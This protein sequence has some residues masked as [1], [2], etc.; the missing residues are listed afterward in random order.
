M[1]N[2]YPSLN[3]AELKSELMEAFGTKGSLGLDQQLELMLSLNKGESELFVTF[4]FRIQWVLKSVG[5]GYTND[6]TLTMLHF[7]MGISGR[8]LAPLLRSVRLEPI[9]HYGGHIAKKCY[10]LDCVLVK[11]IVAVKTTNN[12]LGL[13]T[14]SV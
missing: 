12:L 4:L 14:G 2:R 1:N 9:K 6:N 11:T 3:W 10:Y 13:L 5:T 8:L 7:L